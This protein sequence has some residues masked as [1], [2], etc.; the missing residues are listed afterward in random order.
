MANPPVAIPDLRTA[1]GPARDRLHTD[2]ADHGR[3]LAIG[4][5]HRHCGP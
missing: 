5:L 4:M 2:Q 3:R 1:L